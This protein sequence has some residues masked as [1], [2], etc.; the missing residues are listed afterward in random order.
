M[1]QAPKRKTARNIG[2]NYALALTTG[3]KTHLTLIYFNNVKRG[4]EQDRVKTLANAFLRDRHDGEEEDVRGTILLELGD[5]VSDRCIGVNNAELIRIQR[6]LYDFFLSLGYDLR[7]LLP[8][9]IDL[10]GGQA[11]ETETQT[12]PFLWHN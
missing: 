8:L 12:N 2:K 7:P 11:I 4:F 1:N 6:Q 9:H 10:R 3:K 5:M